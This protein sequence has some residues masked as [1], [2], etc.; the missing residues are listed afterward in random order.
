M[1]VGRF[2]GEGSIVTNKRTCQWTAKGQAGPG[3]LVVDSLGL[4]PWN[5]GGRCESVKHSWRAGV[6]HP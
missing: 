5:P 6:E 4:A 2:V 3:V 1:E